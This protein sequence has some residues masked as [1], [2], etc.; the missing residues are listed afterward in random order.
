MGT[1]EARAAQQDNT[2]VAKNVI[3]FLGDGMS[4]TTL[5]AARIYLGQ[6][7]NTTGEDSRLS[8]EEF[9]YSGFSKVRTHYCVKH[10]P[11]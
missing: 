6:L 4:V 11:F 8:F 5:T 7:Q 9:P 1:L 3:L 10:T 2:G